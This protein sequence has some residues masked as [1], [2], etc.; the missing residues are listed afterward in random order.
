MNIFYFV[1]NLCVKQLLYFFLNCVLLFSE[2]VKATNLRYLVCKNSAFFNLVVDKELTSYEKIL[3]DYEIGTS[4]YFATLEKMHYVKNR[5]FHQLILVCNR[6]DGLPRLFFFKP[7][8]SY[9]YFIISVLQFLYITICIG[10]VSREYL[11]R[12]KQYESEILINLPL[13]LTLMIKSTF[14]EI[15]NSWDN[16]FKG[17]LLR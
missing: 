3:S 7:S 6:N 5:F 9:N 2:E 8:T 12:T 10:W 1:V 14:R 13:A 17:K 4:I 15:P 16:L 11:L